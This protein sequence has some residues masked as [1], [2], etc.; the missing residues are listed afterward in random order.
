MRRS[1]RGYLIWS[2]RGDA[3]FGPLLDHLVRRRQQ[4]FRYGE[5]ERFG[6]LEV[7]DEIETGRLHDREISRLFPLK[8]FAGIEADLSKMSE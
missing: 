1:I 6:G 3:L 4:S 2:H 8:D 5:A 7:D